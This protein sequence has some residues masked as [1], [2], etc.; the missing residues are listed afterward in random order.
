MS[1]NT[2]PVLERVRLS[3]TFEDAINNLVPVDPSAVTLALTTP[4]GTVSNVS[5]SDIIND[6][7]GKYHYDLTVTAAGLWIYRWQGTGA[8]IA[9]SGNGFFQG[10]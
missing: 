1:I 2:Y 4:D 5:G 7:V 6:S 10:V 8:V 9:S 3:V